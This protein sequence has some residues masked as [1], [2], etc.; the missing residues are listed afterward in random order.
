M[1]RQWY[2]HPAAVVCGWELSLP[3]IHRGRPPTGAQARA[4]KARIDH[5]TG[6]QPRTVAPYG[7]LEDLTAGA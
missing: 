2:R 6:H 7:E 3:H 1:V 4:A 5:L